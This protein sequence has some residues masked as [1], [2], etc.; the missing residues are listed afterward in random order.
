MRVPILRG[1]VCDTSPCARGRPA[2]GVC[3]SPNLDRSP[4]W[5]SGMVGR[6]RQGGLPLV[7]HTPRS[8]IRSHRVRLLFRFH[9]VE[10]RVPQSRWRA[11]SRRCFLPARRANVQKPQRAPTPEVPGT[12][13]GSIAP[14][15]SGHEGLRSAASSS[16]SGA[17]ACLSAPGGSAGPS[18]RCSPPALA[19]DPA[20]MAGGAGSPAQETR[21]RHVGHTADSWRRRGLVSPGAEVISFHISWPEPQAEELRVC[22]AVRACPAAR[23]VASQQRLCEPNLAPASHR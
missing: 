5:R 3:T 12:R 13:S 9:Q 7:R 21:R 10:N 6:S 22:P 2:R 1:H 23:R 18:R 19:V 14:N 15:T 16:S 20:D 8:R 17:P 4:R 11:P